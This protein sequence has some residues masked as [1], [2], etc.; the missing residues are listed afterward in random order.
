MNPDD[1]PDIGTI[2]LFVP[3]R[4]DRCDGHGLLPAIV[5]RQ[6]ATGG[7]ATLCLTVFRNDGAVRIRSGV[8]HH[9]AWKARAATDKTWD[10]DGS[11]CWAWPS[12]QASI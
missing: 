6:E 2:L 9:S 4:D 7:D 3:G 1:M 12:E 10:A 8:L 5:Q 11:G